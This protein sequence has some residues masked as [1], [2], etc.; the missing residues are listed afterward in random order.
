MKNLK[1]IIPF[2]LFSGLAFGQ[3][4]KQL[5]IEYFKNQQYEKAIVKFTAAYK[6]QPS[7]EIYKYVLESY[8]ELKQLDEAQVFIKKHLRKYSRRSAPFYIDLGYVQTKNKQLQK[9]ENSFNEVFK[10]IERNPNLAYS[11]SQKF[12]EY[13]FYQEA[14][15]A[16]E[17]AEAINPKLVF[18]FQKAL[19]YADMGD[20][21]NM[22]RSYLTMIDKNKAYY[23]NVLTLMRQTVGSNPQDE[24]NILLKELIVEKIQSTNNP[25]FNSLLVWVLIQEK[26][27]ASAFI[28]LKALDKRLQR[29]QA[30]I[31]NLGQVAAKNL[32]W[33]TA[34]K[35]YDYIIKVG[36]VSPFY[37]D[38]LMEKSFAHKTQI[39]S[40]PSATQEDYKTLLTE[41]QEILEVINYPEDVLSIK[42]AIA[43]IEAYKLKNYDAAVSILEEAIKN[44]YQ[45]TNELAKS[46][47][48]LGDILLAY[49]NPWDALLYYAQVDKAFDESEL[50][51]E[52][53][54][55]KAM[56]AFYEGDFDWA[57][58]QFDVLKSSTSKLISNDAIRMSLVISDNTFL[59]DDTTFSAL[60]LYAKAK[61]YV[62]REAL[63]SALI[64]LNTIEK[65]YPAHSLQ[66]DVLW[67]RAQI[68]LKQNKVNPAVETLEK[69]LAA[70]GQDLLAD[71][72]LFELA[73][74]YDDILNNPQKAMDYYQELFSNHGDS[75]LAS[76]AREKFR[77]LRG[78]EL[79]N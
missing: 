22:Y 61:L 14:L 66:D 76:P 70:Y 58:M 24:G 57:K 69:L 33:K 20:I 60:K 13:G 10:Q 79:Y 73:R 28:Q 53:R 18:D 35:C 31:F 75:I 74:I 43:E 48:L 30:E 34:D 2:L 1:F 39:F 64:V 37:E 5:G 51:Q 55:K 46:K 29:N 50:G 21:D 65:T 7:D 42:R 63:D 36:D 16:F 47:I 77:Q 45:Q 40:N 72:A 41:F 54:F 56:I 11:I 67:E 19:I 44:S 23:N 59:D 4:D 17:T 38:A 52:A 15:K 25:Q 27:F 8:I 32:D 78:D 9:A 3:I 49:G 26:S 68:Y 6:Q 62:A 12:S 71:Q